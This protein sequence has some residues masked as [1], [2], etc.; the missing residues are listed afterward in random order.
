MTRASKILEQLDKRNR[1]LFVEMANLRSKR[2]GLSNDSY[3][4]YI[5]TKE[6]SHGP[7]IKVFKQSEIV[8]KAPSVSISL[9]KEPKILD[10]NRLTLPSSIEKEVK[11][12]VSINHVVLLKLWNV[13]KADT[14]FIEDYLDELEKI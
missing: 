10:E 4:I 12:W 7:R 14:V 13:S 1:K 2:T 6:G 5:S 11:Y 3:V 9:E 8:K